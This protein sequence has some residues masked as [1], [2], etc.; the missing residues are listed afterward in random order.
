MLRVRVSRGSA[1]ELGQQL[2]LSVTPRRTAVTFGPTFDEAILI[3]EE[4]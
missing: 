2:R 3:G 1:A 4:R